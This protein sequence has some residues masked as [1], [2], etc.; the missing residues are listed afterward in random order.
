MP[1]VSKIEIS[2]LVQLSTKENNFEQSGPIKVSHDRNSISTLVLSL[3]EK[4]HLC[5]TKCDMIF[6]GKEKKTAVV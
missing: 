4:L 6:G 1:V 5:L 2:E 3:S